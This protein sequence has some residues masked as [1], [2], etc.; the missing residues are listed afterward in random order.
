MFKSTLIGLAVAVAATAAQATAEVRFAAHVETVAIGQV[1]D[2][3]LQGRSFDL[4]ADGAPI[5]N[6]TG[7]QK[8]NVA[9]DPLSFE[10][11]SVSIDPRWTFAAGN[12]E[13]VIDQASGTL[14][15]VAFGAFPATTDDNFDIATLTLRALAP[16]AGSLALVSGQFIGTVGGKA[17]QLITPSLGQ[18]MVTVVPEPN[19]WALLLAGLGFVGLKLRRR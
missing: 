12:R 18:A 15:G 2:L 7:G 9:Y 14:T 4:S 11:L 13:G 16:G 8:L 19:Q 6:V 5:G 10:L 17:G 3:V 1:F